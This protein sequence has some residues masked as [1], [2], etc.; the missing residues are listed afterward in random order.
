MVRL[1]NYLE[2]LKKKNDQIRGVVDVG[3][4]GMTTDNDARERK[5]TRCLMHPPI[6]RSILVLIM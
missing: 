3:I 1:M 2:V 4:I 6:L 5:C